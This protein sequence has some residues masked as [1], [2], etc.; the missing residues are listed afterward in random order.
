MNVKAL[1]SVASH[2]VAFAGPAFQ[3]LSLAGDV[4]HLVSEIRWLHHRSSRSPSK[5]GWRTCE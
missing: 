2:D 1:S 5:K 4:P 3:Q